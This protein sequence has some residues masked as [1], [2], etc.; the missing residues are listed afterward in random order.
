MISKNKKYLSAKYFAFFTINFIVG[1]GFIATI[2]N[3]LEKKVYGFVVL[4]A[5]SFIAFGVLLV[6]SRLSDTYKETY[7]GSYAYSKDLMYEIDSK[8]NRVLGTKKKPPSL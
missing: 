6:F 2:F 4:A 7:G 5:A 8:G 1:F 3:V